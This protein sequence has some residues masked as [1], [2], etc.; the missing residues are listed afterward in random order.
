M[1]LST[2][3]N[4]A[5]KLYDAAI[6]QLVGWYD[7]PKV[8]GLS[9]SLEKM[10]EADPNFSERSNKC[11]KQYYVPLYFSRRQSLQVCFRFDVNG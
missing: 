5:A 3:S 7:D 10:L 9:G 8:N 11:L 4:E 1:P 2:S 6:T